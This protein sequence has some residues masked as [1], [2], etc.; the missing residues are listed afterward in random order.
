MNR[1]LSI[2]SPPWTDSQLA[3]A[4]SESTNWRSVMLLLGF[5]DRARSAGAIRVV[6]RRAVALNLDFSHFRGKRR[7]S[8]SELREAV[9]ECHSWT[10]VIDRLG[11]SSASGNVQPHVKSHTIRLGL[12]TDHL[13]AISHVRRQPAD[14]IPFPATLPLE[15]RHLRTAAPATAAA[16]FTMRGCVVSFPAEPAVYDLLVDTASGLMRVQV[17]STT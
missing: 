8:D 11:L 13:N 3:D 14:D 5:G 17:K 16:W 6:R 4:I 9:A 10:E 12:D 2:S 1:P 15:S 7:W